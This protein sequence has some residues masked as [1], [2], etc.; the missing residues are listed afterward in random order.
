MTISHILN[1]IEQFPQGEVIT[2]YSHL[3]IRMTL[4][5]YSLELY[6]IYHK[7]NFAIN[8]LSQILSVQ[9]KQECYNAISRQ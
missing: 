6:I 8:W 7:Y 2:S 3:K 9:G 4:I 5:F 1:F